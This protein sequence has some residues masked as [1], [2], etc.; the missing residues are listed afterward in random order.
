MLVDCAIGVP[1]FIQVNVSGGEPSEV[2]DNISGDP[3]I[4]CTT[5]HSVVITGAAESDED[6]N[7]TVLHL[8]LQSNLLLD[9][10]YTPT[11]IL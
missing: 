10:K 6:H 8:A 4:P 3:M 5:D 7:N 1:S 11:L 2:Q 9:A